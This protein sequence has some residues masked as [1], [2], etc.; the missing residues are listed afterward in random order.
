MLFIIASNNPETTTQNNNWEQESLSD[1]DTSDIVDELIDRLESEAADDDI[2]DTQN[3]TETWEDTQTQDAQ[4]NEEWFFSRLFGWTRNDSEPSW[5]E[6]S[7]DEDREEIVDADMDGRDVESEDQWDRQ[8]DI[9]VPHN[10]GEQA[11]WGH[12][13]VWDTWGRSISYEMSYYTSTDITEI[14]EWGKIGSRFHV[15]THSL[16][17]NNKYFDKTLWYLMSWDEL[18]QISERNTYGCFKVDVVMSSTAEGAQGY[19]C[20]RFLEM[21]DEETMIIESSD[22]MRETWL[23]LDTE[24]WDLITITYPQVDIG[25]VALFSGDQIEQLTEIDAWGCFT[26]RIHF[27]Q[28]WW[29]RELLSRVDSFCFENLLR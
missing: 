1:S 16:R 21:I 3:D 11:P 2:W 6:L 4:S 13:T 26:W 12:L 10:E 19:V 9:T 7:N 20:E 5:E 14:S 18:I 23:T 24:I 15:A 27:I 17:L 22:T 29:Y 28:D 25:D 8:T